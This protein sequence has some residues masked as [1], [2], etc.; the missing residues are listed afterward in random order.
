MF[1]RE[2]INSNRRVYIWGGKEEDGRTR[3]EGRF[4]WIDLVS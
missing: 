4:L 2:R 1:L 3:I